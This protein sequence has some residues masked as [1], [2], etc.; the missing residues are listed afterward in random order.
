[1]AI[2]AHSED[3]ISIQDGDDAEDACWQITE[4][5]HTLQ[6]YIESGAPLQAKQSFADLK[7][8]M[9]SLETYIESMPTTGS[10]NG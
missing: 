6:D 9:E 2:R 4:K 8:W 10:E 5:L 7:A 3:A 1:M